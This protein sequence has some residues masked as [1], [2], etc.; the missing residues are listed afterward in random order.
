MLLDTGCL[1]RAWAVHHLQRS[2]P[3][4]THV[5]HHAERFGAGV[6]IAGS[7]RP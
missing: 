5:R 1:R 4:G 7:R 2:L 6:Q 3:G